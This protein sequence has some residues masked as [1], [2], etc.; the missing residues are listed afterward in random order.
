[1]VFL[2]EIVPRRAIAWLANALYNEKYVALPMAHEDGIE[3]D[4]GAVTY[5]WKHGGRW[6]RLGAALGGPPTTPDPDSEE[7]FIT[8]HYYGYVSQRDGSTVEYR[9][10]HPQ[11]PVWQGMKPVFDCDVAA[12]YG[13][14]FASYL[15]GPPSSCFVARGSE[16]IVRRGV[17]LPAAQLP[18]AGKSY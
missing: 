11:W 5:Q 3:N 14:A 12:L 4:T 8:E 18:R 6:C 15:A 13:E 16:I 9:V 10:E 1:V 17:A 7:S 2:K